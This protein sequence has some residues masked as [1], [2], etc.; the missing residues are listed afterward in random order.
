MKKLLVTG[1]CGFIGSNFVRH[2]LS[3]YPDLELVNLDA[4]TYAGRLENLEDVAGDPRYSFVQGDICDA[5][6]VSRAMEGCDAVVNFA[7]ETHVDRSLLGAG[8]F[9]QTDC[10]GVWV[11]L[12]EARRRGVERF[13]QIST[14]E[15][16]GSIEEG[17]FT[18]DAPL[19]PRNPYSASKAGGDRIAY[20]FWASHDVPVI[21]TRASN[22]FG[23]FQYPEKLVPLFVTNALAGRPLPLYGD[24]G[25][26]RDWLYVGDHCRAIEYLLSRG[27]PGEVYNIAGGNERTNLEVT[28]GILDIL[29]KPHDLIRF[30]TD[31][32]G[33]D[34]RYSLDAGKLAALGFAPETDFAAALEATVRWYV[35]NPRWWRPI[36]EQDAEFA[37][38]YDRQYGER[39]GESAT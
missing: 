20:S 12:E 37:A 1:G 33:H 17:S 32:P 15:V 5:A 8:H 11:L 14:D 23:P 21:I 2:M 7:A 6:A 35:D 29:G 19:M 10:Y 28:R 22:N 31:R 9:I 30:V 27:E 38:Y 26:V 3:A 39:L 16:Y 36:R 4:L 18:E 34:R 25:N 13:V 24:G